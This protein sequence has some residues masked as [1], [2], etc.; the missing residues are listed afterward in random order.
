M[1][2]KT[3]SL[4]I[5]FLVCIF[6]QQNTYAQY[7]ITGIVVDTNNFIEMKYTSI[8]IMNSKD[9]ILSDFTRAKEDGHFQ[10]EIKDTGN[11]Y[12]RY[13]HPLFASFIDDIHI[14][15]QITELG[16]VYMISL[17]T[18]LD[19]FIVKESRSITIKG[20][21]TEYTADSFKVREFAT[22]DELLRKL[23]GIEIDKNGK[24]MAYGKNVD[25]MLVDG[26]EFFSDDPAVLSKMLRASS[27]EKVQVYDN[28][29]DEARLSGIEEADIGKAINLTL[30]EDAKKGYFGKLEAGAGTNG[31]YQGQAMINRYRNKEKFSA[32]VIGSNT[33]KVGL[34]WED[35]NNFGSS[36][37][38]SF[39]QS[40]DGMTSMGSGE[41]EFGGFSGNYGGEGLPQTINGGLH[42]DNKYGKDNKNSYGFD[43]RVNSNITNGFSNTNS[44]YTMPD[45]QY[46]SSTNKTF[47]NEN[48]L[49]TLSGKTTIE[50][51]SLN[52]LTIRVNGS[53]NKNRGEQQG[54]SN[55]SNLDGNLINESEQL[56][57]KEATTNKMNANLSYTKKF[58][59]EGRS[60]Y[61]NLSGNYIESGANIDFNSSNEF[62]TTGSSLNYNQNKSDSSIN[63]STNLN[64]S[65]NEPIIKERLFLNLSA[66]TNYNLNSSSNL[67]YDKTP[68]GVDSFNE[69]FS[70]KTDYNVFNN[71]IGGNLRYSNKPWTINGGLKLNYSQTSN[72]DLFR[73]TIYKQNYT[74]IFPSLNVSYS[75]SRNSRIGIRYNGSTRQPSLNQIQVLTQNSDPLNIRIGNPN[76]IQ[77]FRHNLN[78]SYSDYKILSEQY[79]YM[80]GNVSIINNALSE[81][82]T[83]N[84][85][86][87]RTFQTVNLNG[88]W[89]AN[90]WSNYSFK[91]KKLKSNLNIGANGSYIENNTL[92]NNVLNMSKNFSIG[93]NI[94][95]DRWS[96]TGLTFNVS[97][98]PNYNINQNSVN[99]QVKNNLFSSDLSLKFSYR[100][101][102]G[103]EAGMSNRWQNREKMDAYDKN[104]NFII[105]NFFFEHSILKDK[106]LKLRLEGNDIFNQNLGFSR[107]NYNNVIMD[108]E[109]S[110]IQRYFMLVATWNFTKTKS[111]APKKSEGMEFSF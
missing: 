11:Y 10:L 35:N 47:R 49:N 66:G 39:S 31:F 6:L 5:I 22:V 17:E 53:I 76:L 68:S 13:S 18:A 26:D 71:T 92:L 29:S 79:F 4:L 48:L 21:T 99:T 3:C 16:E 105:S 30:K 33:K 37:G 56:S 64:L 42:Y 15:K 34:G 83:I 95:V 63:I 46:L 60:I 20:D 86:G 80:G 57:N 65:Y 7:K 54:S 51:D 70:S 52:S 90:L 87:V 82:Q 104:N 81:S 75:K 107:S 40:D 100:F 96:D 110:T 12:I 14:Q 93:P 43:Y 45:T 61:A 97:Y 106:S 58:K 109:Y 88:N 102:F 72:Q 24:I 9:S 25:K 78:L 23:P 38:I 98:S 44:R 55:N 19:E 69:L 94:G 108:A 41:P 84:S 101:P 2:K 62:F 74:N 28:K 77:E 111:G 91:I 32:Y 50:I 85:E 59:K 103:L 27:I 73:D 1:I 36:G 89:N 8:A 67:T